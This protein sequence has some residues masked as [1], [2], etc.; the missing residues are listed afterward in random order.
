[1]SNRVG[2]GLELAGA[3]GTGVARSV[4]G[5][6]RRTARSVREIALEAASQLPRLVRLDQIQPHTR[7]LARAAWSTTAPGAR[8]MR[9]SSCSAI[10]RTPPPTSTGASTTSCAA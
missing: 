5:T 4:A 7:D 1:M 10:A 3:V 2:Y 8:R 6:A 9:S